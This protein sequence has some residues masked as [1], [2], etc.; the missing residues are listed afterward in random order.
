[1][2]IFIKPFDPAVLEATVANLLARRRRLREHF[3]ATGAPPETLALAPAAKPRSQLEGEPRMVF[4]RLT[5]TELGAESLA[6]AMGMSCLQLY[7]AMRGRWRRPPPDSFEACVSSAQR[8]AAATT[9]R[10]AVT[11]V[12]YSVGFELAEELQPRVWR[13]LRRPA[14]ARIGVGRS[15]GV[16]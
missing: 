4:G 3:A 11:E 7:R 15:I 10:G 2:R 5:D 8:G 14:G 1:M 12:A 16:G 9:E 13:A 6:E